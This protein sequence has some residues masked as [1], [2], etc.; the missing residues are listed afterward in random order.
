MPAGAMELQ[1]VQG[2][3]GPLFSFVLSLSSGWRLEC[4]KTVDS[5]QHTL[6]RY[7]RALSLCRVAACRCGESGQRALVLL[8][9]RG[10][11]SR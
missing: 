9:S 4:V 6:G 3:A 10:R 11:G 7:C 5:G 8:P 1:L 2:A